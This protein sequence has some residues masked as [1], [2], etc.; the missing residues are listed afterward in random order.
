MDG[1][2]NTREHGNYV[3][4]RILLGLAAIGFVGCT[5]G[6]YGSARRDYSS[7]I[8]L[9]RYQPGAPVLAGDT[10]KAVAVE[11]GRNTAL[12][13]IR[14]SAFD[15]PTIAGI[16]GD[17]ELGRYL[18]ETLERN[19]A[20]ERA[21]QRAVAA[22]YEMARVSS[23]ADPVLTSVLPTG[24]LTE[25]AA[26]RV[27]GSVG[28][29][30][31]IPFPGKLGL[32]GRVAGYRAAVARA[33]YQAVLLTIVK[34]VRTAYYSLYFSDRAIEITKE[35]RRLLRDF[36]EIAARK[37]ESGV[38]PQQDLL[39][40]QVELANLESELVALARL[41]GT[42]RARLNKLM[43]APVDRP[44]PT[45]MRQAAKQVELDLGAL[46]R[47][48]DDFSPDIAAARAEVEAAADSTRLARLDYFPDLTF[49]YT[50]TS[51]LESGLSG[52]ATGDDV[53]QFGFGI[54]LPIWYEKLAA[55]RKQAGARLRA[56]EDGLADATDAVALLVE[57]SM[58]K[59]REQRRLV[60]LFGGVI[61][62]EARQ[63]LD[64]TV[65]AYRAGQVDF[66]TLV[67]NWRRLLDFKVSFQRS[68]STLEKELAELERIVGRPVAGL[69]DSSAS[70]SQVKP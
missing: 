70:G 26:G 69:Q 20:L 25:T 52:S 40:A 3:V 8:G 65:S 48:A 11:S 46:L 34:D 68:L 7:Y 59:V 2:R 49:G 6:L 23:L 27:E 55:G 30:Q 53:G 43:A 29:S 13:K 35:S 24:D 31:H 21:R 33:A 14:R 10:P 50:Y 36:R 17:N 63:T 39:R 47:A 57:E 61:I 62:P 5:T 45:T 18:T 16:E 12:D 56:A 44:L 22:G 64:A 4:H 32:K 38:V 60:D 19:P 1:E 28:L 37:Y 9:G 42:A 51:V 15:R 41:R 66:L 54:N 58:L 67:E